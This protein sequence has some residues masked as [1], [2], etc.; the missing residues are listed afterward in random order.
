M[1]VA[2]KPTSDGV[3]TISA[4]PKTIWALPG[5]AQIK[6][7]ALWGRNSGLTW[8]TVKHPPWGPTSQERGRALNYEGIIGRC[9]WIPWSFMVYAAGFMRIYFNKTKN[10][11]KNTLRDDYFLL[12]SV[13]FLYFRA[14]HQDKISFCCKVSS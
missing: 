2:H 13:C 5:R 14:L 11:R 6:C 1:C 9:P 8:N 3:L 4:S 12:F 10:L 7:V